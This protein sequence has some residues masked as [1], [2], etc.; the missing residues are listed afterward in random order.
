MHSNIKF[1]NMLELKSKKKKNKDKKDKKENHQLPGQF[2]VG[3]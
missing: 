1:Q 2:L 3:L